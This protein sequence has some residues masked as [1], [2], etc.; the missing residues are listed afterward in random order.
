MEKAGYKIGYKIPSL[1]TKLSSKIRLYTQNNTVCVSRWCNYNLKLP[2]TSTFLNQIKN[3]IYKIVILNCWL[4]CVPEIVRK[5][6][7]LV[8]TLYACKLHV[9]ECSIDVFVLLFLIKICKTCKKPSSYGNEWQNK[10]TN[11]V[12]TS[13]GDDLSRNKPLT[14]GSIIPRTLKGPHPE[15]MCCL[16]GVLLVLVLPHPLEAE[17]LKG[18]HGGKQVFSL[19]L[20]VY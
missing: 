12:P 17:K 2:K 19:S 18:C 6:V 5:R 20:G 4:D 11:C 13:S 1:W 3:V 15:Y 7:W 10:E 14:T 16:D 9:W 8:S